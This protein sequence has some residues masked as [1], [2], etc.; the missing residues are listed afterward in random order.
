MRLVHCTRSYIYSNSACIP[1][2]KHDSICTKNEQN[3]ACIDHR[4]RLRS[5][6]IGCLRARMN[7]TSVPWSQNNRSSCVASHRDHVHLRNSSPDNE[8]SLPLVAWC[9]GCCESQVISPSMKKN[10]IQ[11]FNTKHNNIIQYID[12]KYTKQIL[13]IYMYIKKTSE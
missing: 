6:C 4:T 7:L 2:I 1:R 11:Q 3:N 9:L 8:F 10:E 12:M 5:R 13:Y